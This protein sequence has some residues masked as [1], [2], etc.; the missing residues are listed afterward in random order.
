MTWSLFVFIILFQRHYNISYGDEV[1][2][3]CLILAAVELDWKQCSWHV[4]IDTPLRGV[5]QCHLCRPNSFLHHSALV[6]CKCCRSAAYLGLIIQCISCFMWEDMHLL[7]VQKS[8]VFKILMPIR[9][10]LGGRL[11]LIR[12]SFA[13]QFFPF[14]V[15]DFR[16]LLH[17]VTWLF[18]KPKRP[19]YNIEV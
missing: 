18:H 15:T 17:K 8:F 3:C 19:Q 13:S 4:P 2:Q 9:Y 12:W 14:L 16:T 6:K 11:H 10:C 1:V 7:P 5:W